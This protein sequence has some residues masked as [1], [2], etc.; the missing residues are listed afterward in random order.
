MAL[1]S[2]RIHGGAETSILRCVQLSFIP[3]LSNCHP[4]EQMSYFLILQV[5]EP[6]AADTD[7][8]NPP[9]TLLQFLAHLQISMEAMFISSIP[10]VV[11]EASPASS[12]FLSA[13]PRTAASRLNPRSAASRHH[14]SIFPPA[15]P[16]PMPAV[17]QNDRQ[18][19]NADGTILF[20]GIW[21]Q[22]ASEAFTL[23]WSEESKAWIA[24]F[25]LALAVGT[26]SRYPV[27]Q[28]CSNTTSL[29]QTDILKSLAVCHCCSNTSRETSISDSTQEP[30]AFLLDVLS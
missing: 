20:S 7:S 5:D 18:Y 3:S 10:I 1:S 25:K 6:G 21:G 9:S 29:Y 11:T 2:S 19:L 15:T 27:H 16:N 30:F 17:A 4:D 28:K 26:Y 23:F 14:P 24:V 8:S 13:P 22:D 12:V